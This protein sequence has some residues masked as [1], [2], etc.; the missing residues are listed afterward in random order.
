MFWRNLDRPFAGTD[1][2]QS[3]AYM[4]LFLQ[5][6]KDACMGQPVQSFVQHYTKIDQMRNDAN[7]IKL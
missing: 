6:F 5:G 7:L 2:Y 3:V 4:R 1:Q